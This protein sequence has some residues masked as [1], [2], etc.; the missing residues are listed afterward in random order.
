MLFDVYKSLIL[1][2]LFFFGTI[3]YFVDDLKLFSVFGF[4]GIGFAANAAEHAF[5]EQDS[6]FSANKRHFCIILDV[7]KVNVFI[8]AFLQFLASHYLGEKHSICSFSLQK[9]PFYRWY[10]KS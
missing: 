8:K 9:V 5:V 1:L 6:L 3:I 10:Y 2:K 7:Y 4:V